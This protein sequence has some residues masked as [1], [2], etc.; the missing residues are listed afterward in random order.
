MLRKFVIFA[1]LLFNGLV[2]GAAFAI[3][4][5]YNPTGMSPSFYAQKMQHAIRI[6]TVPLPTVVILAVLFAIA[7]AVLARNDRSRFLLLVAASLCVIAVALITAFG[8]IP[9]NN[10]IKT[11]N[12]S[13]PPLNWGD[14]GWRWWYF[15]TARTLAA[16]GGLCFLIIAT[17]VD[18]GRD[19]QH[20]L[21]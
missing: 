8:N 1:A 2:A 16:I 12:I 19:N 13:S 11:W 10:Q 6:F 20:S 17:L 4:I 14:L 7:S 15:Q 18:P 21:N 9:I 3:W 5:D